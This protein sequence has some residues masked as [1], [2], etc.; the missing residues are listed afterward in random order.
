MKK[1]SLFIFV[2]VA[3]LF[4]S[5]CSHQYG[6][7]WRTGVDLIQLERLKGNASYEVLGSTEGR[8]TV[9][10][11]LFFTFGDKYK[12]TNMVGTTF[13]KN[14]RGMAEQA[15]CYNAIENFEGADELLSPRFNT[16]VENNFF[17]A[18]YTATVKAKAVKIITN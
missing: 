4:I 1:G 6:T 5:G 13:Q 3:G 2:I 15:A 17:Y 9:T 10:R 8:A 18:T 7:M 11:V 12:H 14:A 16:E